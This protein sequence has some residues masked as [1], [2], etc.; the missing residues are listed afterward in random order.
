MLPEG[1]E[2]VAENEQAH[3]YEDD[4]SCNKVHRLLDALSVSCAVSAFRK[5][6]RDTCHDESK[7]GNEAASDDASND[8]ND[9]HEAVA[10]GHVTEES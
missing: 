5:C 3:G 8:S 1:E 6:L 10:T 9:Q 7:R 4:V 2:D